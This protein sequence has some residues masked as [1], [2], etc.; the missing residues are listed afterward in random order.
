ME[1]KKCPGIILISE[2]NLVDGEGVGLGKWGIPHLFP[3]VLCHLLFP[4]PFLLWSV[5]YPLWPFLGSGSVLL[6]L[7]HRRQQT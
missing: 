3:C 2:F 7:S 6:S 4:T 1:R 5:W